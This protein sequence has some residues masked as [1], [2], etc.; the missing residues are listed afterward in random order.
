MRLDIEFLL[1]GGGKFMSK[2]PFLEE[3]LAVRK[4]I[5]VVLMFQLALALHV[6]MLKYIVSM[7]LG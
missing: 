2:S 5:L 6:A 4:A 7:S 3:A 1:G